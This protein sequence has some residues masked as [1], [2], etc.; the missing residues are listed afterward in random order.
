MPAMDSIN[1]NA[2]LTIT[3]PF[4]PEGGDVVQRGRITSGGGRVKIAEWSDEQG[5]FREIDV[6]ESAETTPSGDGFLITGISRT[7]SEE[8]REPVSIS[9]KV[10]PR[11]CR[12]C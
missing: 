10:A 4:S 2:V 3:T 9:V 12:R 8:L 6:I 1:T 7:S 5:R 11:G